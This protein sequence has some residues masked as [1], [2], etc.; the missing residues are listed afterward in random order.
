MSATSPPRTSKALE[1]LIEQPDQ[2][3]VLNLGYG[4][5][6]S[7]LEVLDALDRCAGKPIRRELKGRRAGDPPLLISSN[8][9]LLETLDWT[10][11]FADID[12]IL[13]P[14]AGVGTQAAEAELGVKLTR[15][16]LLPW[17]R[18]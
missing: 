5:G 9:A 6:L 8:E 15:L 2:N 18:C 10:P 3:L 12:T 11:R 7:V 16:P 14:C 13:D 4:R 1:R 17:R